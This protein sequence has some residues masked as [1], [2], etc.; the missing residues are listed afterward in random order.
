M[1]I[2]THQDKLYMAMRAV[3]PEKQF[4]PLIHTDKQC[5]STSKREALV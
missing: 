1:K 2:A 4:S 5:V 3:L